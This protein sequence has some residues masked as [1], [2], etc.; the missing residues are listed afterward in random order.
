MEKIQFLFRP[1]SS[2]GFE[3][4][5]QRYEVQ[6]PEEGFKLST[7]T[8]PSLPQDATILVCEFTIPITP[9]VI[10]YFPNL[11]LIANYA[12]GFNNIDVAYANSKGIRVAN[13]PQA[14]VQSTAEL[15]LGLLLSVSRRVA[16]WDRL[17]RTKRS[18]D[19]GGLH[20]G[21]GTDLKGRKAGI[22]GYGN[23]G[24]AVGRMMQAFGIEVVYNKRHPLTP[25]EEK[26]LG[27]SYASQEEI[28][29]GCDIISLHTPYTA[30]SHHLVN[31][32]T[33][34]MMKPSAILLNAARGKVV[35][36]AALVQALKEKRI[37]GAGLDVFEYDDNPLDELY[38]LPNVVMT[39]HVGTQ[40][41]EARRDMAEELSNNVVGFVEGDRPV[42]YVR[43]R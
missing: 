36:E 24:R 3:E 34:A 2:Q 13:T 16:E 8:L 6:M 41:T 23:I 33:L 26:S 35:D 17:M 39:P 5:M 28:F 25:D 9:E 30:E 42:A 4:L 40:T 38:D 12:V 11:K 32:R 10:D 20:A 22:I 19:K 21:M 37:F 15:T 27:I 7:E 14:V 43:L 18:S 29:R 31:A 1:A